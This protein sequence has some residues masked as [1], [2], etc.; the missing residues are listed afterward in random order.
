MLARDCAD[1]DMDDDPDVDMGIELEAPSDN[2]STS[3][4]A[5]FQSLLTPLLSLIQPTSLSFPPFSGPSSHPPTTSVLSAIHVSALECLNNIFLSMTSMSRSRP[6][7]DPEIGRKIWEEIWLALTAVGTDFGGSGQEK[8]K[9]LWEIGVGVLWGVGN[10]WKGTLL[11]KEDQVQ[12]LMQFNDAAASNSVRVKCIGT[13]ECLA[14]H[15]DSINTNRVSIH[16]SMN[17]LADADPCYSNILSD[18]SKLSFVPSSSVEKPSDTHGTSCSS[19]LR[20]N[21]HL[22]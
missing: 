13:L 15:P 17:E 16:C 18:Y 2:A 8:R 7:F 1:E 11:P 12:L 19:S 22:F 20:V 6:S 9:E 14:Q 10:A 4:P 5:F 21:R 3:P